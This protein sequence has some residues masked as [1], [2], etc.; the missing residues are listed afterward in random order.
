MRV[1]SRS[2][3]DRSTPS[4][5]E[6]AAVG[7]RLRRDVAEV[8]HEL[9]PHDAQGAERP[10]G[11]QPHRAGGGTAAALLRRDPVAHLRRPARSVEHE[12]AA[13]EQRVGDGVGDH[14]VGGGAGPDLVAGVAHEGLR[15]DA[16]STGRARA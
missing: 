10:L 14:E 9:H 13:A 1:P 6:P 12:A 7:D 3:Y 15:V 5:L 4:R 16:R 11:E 8:G 2:S